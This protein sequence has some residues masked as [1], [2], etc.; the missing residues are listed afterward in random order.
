MGK[1]RR[2]VIDRKTDALF[3]EAHVKS[4]GMMRKIVLSLL[5]VITL[6]SLT[7]PGREIM[8]ASV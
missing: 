7:V 6:T 5:S 4:E 1:D 2:S 8:E 3:Y